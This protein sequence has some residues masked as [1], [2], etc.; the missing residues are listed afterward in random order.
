MRV[1]VALVA[2]SLGPSLGAA[3]SLG[4]AA[5]KQAQRRDQPRATEVK[6]FSDADLAAR[7][8]APAQESAANATPAD[9][10]DAAAGDRSP[11]EDQ[12]RRDLER[13]ERKRSQQEAY[14]RQAAAACRERVANAKQ[15]Y[16]YVCAGGTLLTGG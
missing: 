1:L 6:V 7:P 13:E 2:V 8:D 9:A 11:D 15:A 3:D 16:D 14:W 12:L 4:A 10:G 5:R